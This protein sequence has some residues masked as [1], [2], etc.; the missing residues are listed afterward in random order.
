LSIDMVRWVGI[1]AFLVVLV[2][3]FLPWWSIRASG[4]AIDVYPLGVRAWNV[5]VYDR[6]WVVDRLLDLKGLWVVGLLVVVSCI[7][8]L[9]GSLRFRPLLVVPV[10]LNMV[11]VLFFHGLIV[12]ALGDLAYGCFSGTNLVPQGPWGF[13]VG[14]GLPVLAAI[15][16]PF[17]FLV[18]K[19]RL[20]ASGSQVC[21]P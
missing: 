16:L 17:F 14:V 11:A 13:T 19:G 5:P 20:V 12:S 6:D 4:M 7:L 1:A 9:A 2:S 15:V 8:A 18:V 21:S 10:V 3:L